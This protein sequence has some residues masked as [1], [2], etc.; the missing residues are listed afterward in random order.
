MIHLSPIDPYS[1]TR[2]VRRARLGS[3]A[4]KLVALTLADYASPDGSNVRPGNERLAAVTELGEKSVR[5]ALEALR[6]LGLIERVFEGSKA[7]RRGLADVYRLTV[8]DDLGER[9]EMLAPD[10]KTP[11]T[12]T[13]VTGLAD[14]SEPVSPDTM[15]GDWAAADTEHRSSETGS[16]VTDDRNTGHHDRPPTSTPTKTPTN[17]DGLRDHF[18]SVEGDSEHAEPK[19]DLGLSYA[20]AF[21][22]IQSLGGEIDIFVADIKADAEVHGHDPPHG[23]ELTIAVAKV[24]LVKYP[25]LLPERRTA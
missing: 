9:V 13:G 10:E 18:G 14:P 16:P 5:R 8:P 1:W 17:P 25:Q 4:T 12:V 20:D 6:V 7:G 23:K 24:A 2:L 15:T 21:K 22:V 11:D 19:S 3:S